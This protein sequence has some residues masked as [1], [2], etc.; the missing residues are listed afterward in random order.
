MTVS[1]NARAEAGQLPPVIEARAHPDLQRE[2]PSEHHASTSMQKPI[3]GVC[4]VHFIE[5][6]V[7]YHLAREPMPSPFSF[8]VPP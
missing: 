6:P 1:N 8:A 5:E 2:Q 3:A 4:L 7:R